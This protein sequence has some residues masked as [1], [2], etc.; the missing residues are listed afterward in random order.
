MKLVMSLGTPSS[1]KLVK[2]SWALNAKGSKGGLSL[3]CNGSGNLRRLPGRSVC[4]WLPRMTWKT[5]GTSQPRKHE[6]LLSTFGLGWLR[7]S[8]NETPLW[9]DEN[10]WFKKMDPARGWWIWKNANNACAIPYNGKYVWLLSLALKTLSLCFLFFSSLQQG[11][12]YQG[13]W[14]EKILFPVLQGQD[15]TLVSEGE[16]SAEC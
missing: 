11:T 16:W 5:E 15:R 4:C 2:H 13:S 6:A 8:L 9:R 10:N 7:V 14:Y 12:R 3:S 1:W